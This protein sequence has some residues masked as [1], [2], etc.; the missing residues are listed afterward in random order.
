MPWNLQQIN[1]GGKTTG[2]PGSSNPFVS[3]FLKGQQHVFYV[4]GGGEIGI[5]WDSFYDAGA[6]SWNLQQIN[7]GGKTNGPAAT[8]GALFV[9]VFLKGQQHVF[10]RDHSGVIWD[11]FYDAGAR[12]WNL[13]QINAGGK[14]DGPLAEL[15]GLCASVFLNAQ[16][17]VFY[18]DTAGAIWDSFYDA[19]AES[20][21]LQQINLGGKTNGP[22]GLGGLCASVFLNAQQHVFYLDNYTGVIWDSFYDAGAGSWNLQQIN[23]GGKTDGPTA[24]GGLFASVFLNAQQHVFYLD[25]AGT[26]WDSFYDAGAGSWNLQQINTGGKTM[27][28]AAALNALFVSVFLNGQQHVFYVDG[29]GTI[30]D[31][32]YDAGGGSWNLQQINAGGK[33]DGPAALGPPFVSVFLNEQQ[34]VFYL[35]DAGTVWDSYYAVPPL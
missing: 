18:L 32:F 8:L 33:T 35:D 26:I 2:P 25:S 15:S 21:N 10:Y 11:S 31:S 17:H 22:A 14:T 12:S 4:Q 23:A 13:Q 34:H 27:G 29:A 7:A 6:G 5:I 19:D 30:W 16:Q 28:P 3:V 1:A 9:S 24:V 20:W